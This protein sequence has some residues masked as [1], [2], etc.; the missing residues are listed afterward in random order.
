MAWLGPACQPANI[1]PGLGVACRVMPA[2]GGCQE[3]VSDEMGT[4]FIRMAPGEAAQESGSL[5]EKYWMLNLY[6]AL[7]LATYCVM[8]GSAVTVMVVCGSVPPDH[9]QFEKVNMTD[10]AWLYDTPVPCATASVCLLPIGQNALMTWAYTPPY[11]PPSTPNSGPSGE[12]DTVVKVVGACA[13]LGG[14]RPPR[15][16]I[17][18]VTGTNFD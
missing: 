9:C 3:L 15:S 14:A 4:P 13:C 17:H 7:K 16:A 2:P 1:Q 8:V 12:Q 10:K 11:A 18:N 5:Q 6:R